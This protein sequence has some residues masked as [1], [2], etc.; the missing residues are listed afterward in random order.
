MMEVLERD[1]LATVEHEVT[2]S[3]PTMVDLTDEAAEQ[4]TELRSRTHG[5]VHSDVVDDA[6]LSEA[7][8]LYLREINGVPLLKADQEVRLANA[9]AA[10][11]AAQAALAE[12]SGPLRAELQAT[13]AKGE[14]ARQ[15]LIEANLRLVVS[16][17]RKY[18]GRGLP[19]SD[20]I[21]EG[22]LGLFRAVERF[23]P[24]REFR[25]STYAYWWIRQAV[26]RSIADQG[27]TI[28]LPVHM[29]ELIG[30]V[31]RVSAELQQRLGRE[32]EASEIAKVLDISAEKV[33]LALG[34]VPRP[35]SLEA[36]VTEDGNTIGEIVADDTA[37]SPCEAAELASLRGHLDTALAQLT[38]RER[39]VIELRFGLVGDRAHSLNEI[40]EE[41][42][43][44]RER[45]RQ[46]EREAVGKL[47]RLD[48]RR[49][50]GEF[51]A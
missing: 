48:L 34:S 45:V 37:V 50:L 25:F 32:P 23:D 9:L 18:A 16:V 41:L 15:T 11:R 6:S 3:D 10:G 29:I 20:L 44:S 4:A 2:I 8:A 12:A 40:G 26:S 5:S 7:V 22:N 39:R 51:A 24:T 49:V 36:A 43:V 14:A 46:I 33:R 17:A 30:R 28:R 21:Q 47:R 13:I 42:R 35:A 27:R 1:M 19:L 38:D 31:A